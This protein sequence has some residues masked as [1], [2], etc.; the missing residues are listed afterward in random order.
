MSTQPLSDHFQNSIDAIIAM[1]AD[2]HV[3]APTFEE[4]AQQL[5]SACRTA[6]AILAA[7]RRAGIPDPEPDPWPSSTW[8]F[9]AKHAKRFR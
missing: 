8:D 6:A 4:R 3:L 7:R 5:A 2:A 1:E 9:L